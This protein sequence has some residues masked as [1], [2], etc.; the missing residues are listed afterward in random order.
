MINTAKVKDRRPLRFET[1]EEAIRDAESL[2]SADTEGRLRKVG[3]WTPGE[4]LTHVAYWADAPFDGYP[5][6]MKVPWFMKLLMKFM[7]GGIF[8]NGMSPGVK[9]PNTP[10]GTY[11]A[12]DVPSA[13]AL[14]RLRS[15][16]TR[17]DE[18]CPPDPNPLFGQ[19]THEQWKAL[20]LRHAELHF[21]FFH[22][23]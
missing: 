9:I 2:V 23:E 20:N 21:G 19:M 14:E 5:E 4:A 17:I 12:E 16:F 13:E 8:K 3:N 22:P 15:A 18:V 6:G 7:R 1:I 11:G 10:G